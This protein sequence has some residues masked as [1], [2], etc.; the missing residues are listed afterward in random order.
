MAAGASSGRVTGLIKDH[1]S[2]AFPLMPFDSATEKF[3]VG[4]LGRGLPSVPT[5]Q[6]QGL[7]GESRMI[8]SSPLGLRI[9]KAEQH[10]PALTRL[11]RLVGLH[12]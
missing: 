6:D 10:Q 4:R 8:G 9:K 7:S 5:T 3:L 12:P 2:A 11:V 1:A